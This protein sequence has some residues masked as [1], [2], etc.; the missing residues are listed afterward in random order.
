MD[1]D[2][3]WRGIQT[4]LEGGPSLGVV[5]KQQNFLFCSESFQRSHM[6]SCLKLY[7][8]V[9]EIF[10]R[11]F[12]A[13]TRIC[14]YIYI[15]IYIYVYVCMYICIYIMYHMLFMVY[16]IKP[17]TCVLENYLEKNTCSSFLFFTLLQIVSK[18]ILNYSCYYLNER[19]GRTRALP[20]ISHLSLVKSKLY[21]A[22]VNVK[23]LKTIT[24]VPHP[25]NTIKWHLYNCEKI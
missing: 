25:S 6:F 1:P 20:W 8:G 14:K 15:Y 18:F 22:S 17:F 16:I 3:A 5:I 9:T 24:S 19:G 2:L 10:K 12:T 7:L 23:P 21:K 4:W 11:A 13:F